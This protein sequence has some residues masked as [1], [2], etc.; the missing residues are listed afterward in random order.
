VSTA[1]GAPHPPRLRVRPFV[2]PYRGP[3]T[4]AVAVTLGQTVVTL[5]QPWPLKLVVDNALG[6]RPLTGWLAPLNH[7]SAN[8]LAGVAAAAG[9]ALVGAGALLGYLSTYLSSAG[10]ERVGADIRAAVH[11]R[12]LFLPIRFHDRNR[13]GELVSRLVSDVDRVQDA[14]VASLT[15]LIPGLLSLVGIFVLMILIDPV[16][17]LAALLV[18]PVLTVVVVAR[19]RR[20]RHAQLHAREEEGRLASLATDVVRNVR[21]VQAFSH[22]P[23]A[24]SD[25]EGQNLKATGASIAAMDLEARYSPLADLVIAGGSAFVLWFGVTRVTSGRLT[26]GL[27]LVFLSYLT[28][29][30]SPVRSLSRLAR[31]MA[32][33]SASSERIAEIVTD[34]E[35]VFEDP[36]AIPAGPPTRTISLRDVSF[37]Y[38]TGSPVLR[39]VTLDI[40]AGQAVCLVGPSGVGKSTMLALFLRF[41]DPDS[42]ALEIDGTDLRRF[43]VASLRRQVAF[44]PQDAWIVDGTIAQNIAF[45]SP[46]A[47]PT[48]IQRAAETALVDEF[49]RRLPEGYDT[50]VGESGALLSGGQRR[51]VALARAVLR[52]APILLLDEPTT[53]LDPSSERAVVDAI[54]NASVGKTLVM[55]SHRIGVAAIA[56]RVA[57]VEGGRITALDSLPGLLHS[58][59]EFA[60]MWSLQQQ[61]TGGRPPSAGCTRGRRPTA[62]GTPLGRR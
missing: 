41:Y 21:A 27:L 17:S 43:S 22:E 2:G 23:R 60:R 32:K 4:V 50:I 29:L 31:T 14:M 15:T 16:L 44:V 9:V 57:V 24:Q 55:A 13:S 40:P 51:R 11:E 19:R 39:D 28:S 36:H 33:A 1:R 42:G 48:E 20:I 53:G 18:L 52:D 6:H 25:F 37:A 35:P 62:F 3:L 61:A 46:D 56:D 59:R 12:L 38:T 58:N 30:Y 54:R 10:A 8:A 34:A 7:L 45:G 26:L 5:L 49:A 47:T